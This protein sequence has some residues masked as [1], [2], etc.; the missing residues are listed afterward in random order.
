MGLNLFGSSKKSGDKTYNY[1][2]RQDNSTNIQEGDLAAGAIRSD[3]DV[4]ITDGGAI[5]MAGDLAGEAFDLS[6]STTD[7]ALDFGE[8]S[9][10]ES[11]GFGRDSLE[12]VSDNSAEVFDA[13]DTNNR[14]TYD[15]VEST[16]A[17][18]SNGAQV[19]ATSQKMMIGLVVLAGLAIW[20]AR[21]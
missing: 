5:D 6:E 15:L 9:L 20:G 16:T 12:L 11:Y 18:A 8:R 2:N 14:R 10:V 13:I 19:A 1:D 17:R 4:T 3:G 21:A 7:R